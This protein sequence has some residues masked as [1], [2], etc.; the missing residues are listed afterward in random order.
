MKQLKAIIL[1]FILGIGW[2]MHIVLAKA[3]GVENFKDAVGTLM[4]YMAGACLGTILLA[5]IFS[6]LFIP[7]KNQI[8]F[9]LVSAILGYIGPI[10]A[11]FVIA[12]KIDASIFTLIA[13]LTPIPAVIIMMMMKK[14]VLTFRLGLALI[15]GLFGA[16]LL[17]WPDLQ[18][19]SQ[20]SI[21]YLT[22]AFSVPL[23][24][25]LDNIYVDLKWPSGVDTFQISVYE[26][27][28]ALILISLLGL[29]MGIEQSDITRL[30]HEGGSPLLIMISA[31]LI[32]IWL[33][34]HLI[35]TYGAVM[36]SFAGFISLATG[37]IAGVY[38]FGEQP[39][40]TMWIACLFII[41]S[42]ILLTYDKTE[43]P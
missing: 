40:I 16:V 14:A 9:F 12:P 13:A 22:A 6:K 19:S 29:A 18:A 25:A 34:F 1:L 24:Y 11:E 35:K 31:T 32:T 7:Q 8:T 15:L 23:F 3:I 27:F 37:I 21:V 43:S 39:N 20:T 5:L 30:A 42:L 17:L 41:I 33:F 26:S 38:Y 4:I 36:V 28:F 10:L 2:G